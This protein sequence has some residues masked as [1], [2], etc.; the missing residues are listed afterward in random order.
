MFFQRTDRMFELAAQDPEECERLLKLYRGRRKGSFVAFVVGFVGLLVYG[1][2]LF[3]QVYHLIQ[4]LSGTGKGLSTS[5]DWGIAKIILFPVG[6]GA[7][8]SLYTAISADSMTKAN[9]L[10]RGLQQG[11]VG[12]VTG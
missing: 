6:A 7:I 11:R 10:V 9:L 3:Y 2:W 8:A 12:K 1:A 5:P 4:A